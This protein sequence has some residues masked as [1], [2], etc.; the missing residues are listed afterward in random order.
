MKKIDQYRANLS[1]ALCSLEKALATPPSE[2]RDYAGI[3]QN[4]EFVYE[5][6]WKT[7]KLILEKEG[8]EAPFPRVVFEEAFK[9]NILEGNE[10]W[11][12][13]IESRNLSAHT[14]DQNLA[15]NLV[16][17]ITKEYQPVFRKTFERIQAYKAQ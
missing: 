14:Y 17:R 1:K 8:I 2:D 11:K 4:F 15:K 7:L 16:E 5:L 10:I 13:I 9:R 6:T 12:N 3:I